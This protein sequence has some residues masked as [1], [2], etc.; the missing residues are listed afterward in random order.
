[1]KPLKKSLIDH[2]YIRVRSGKG[3]D[4]AISFRREKFIPKGGPDGGDGGKGGDVIIKA[5]KNLTTLQKFLYEKH[6][7]A[8]NGENGG[9]RLKHGKNGDD[10]IIEVPV[11]TTIIDRESGKVIAELNKD[12][13]SVVI[14]K[15]GK[16]GRGNKAFTTSTERAP[17]YSE[18]GGPYEE[19]DLELILK[20]ISDVGIVG[21]PNAGKS[22]FISKVSNAHPEIASYPFTTLSPKIG[23]VKL[24]E[25][26]S[27]TIADLPGLIEGASSGKGLGNQFLS[28][29]EKTKVLMFLID[30]EDKKN[31]KKAYKIL[32][33]E[34]G[35]YKEELLKK[36]RIIVINKIDTWKVKR[37][38]ELKDFFS[39]VNE[40]VY[41]ISALNGTGVKEVLERLYELVKETHEEESKAE[42]SEK[43]FTL[44]RTKEIIIEKV[45]EHTFKVS[46]PEL[47][48]H[49]ELTDF[50]RSGS[51]NELLR[52]FDKIDLDKKLKKHGIKEGDRVI[53][54]SKSFIYHED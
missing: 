21:F 43:E 23:V 25:M 19:K 16:G 29:I 36:K 17:R 37:T 47:E 38:K 28:H 18:K 46:N 49:A 27:F 26:R 40:E 14:A 51:V 42:V 53:I 1:M 45:D 44:D 3:G 54:G 7:F 52:Y 39:R 20:V 10:L 6:F 22:T 48:R 15:G 13:E 4:G 33:K 41:F 11:G 50:N 12:G 8:E 32:L 9:G 34:L 35:N 31:I 5:N 24:D 30:G 2:A